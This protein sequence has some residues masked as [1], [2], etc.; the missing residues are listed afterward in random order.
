M[1]QRPMP[2]FRE[3][4]SFAA[5]WQQ[6]TQRLPPRQR[7]A[8]DAIIKH[9]A[10]QKQTAQ[11]MGISRE[12]ARQ[13]LDRSM[14]AIRLV[15]EQNPDSELAY[16][17]GA[18]TDIA[19]TAGLA[20][21][22]FHRMAPARR[23][24]I[25]ERIISAGALDATE[26]DMLTTACRLME[27]PPRQHLS[28]ELLEN[29][30]KQMLQQNPEG[31][32]PDDITRQH[33]H[34]KPIVASWPRLD[35]AQFVAMHLPARVTPQGLLCSLLPPDPVSIRQ[36]TAN[37]LF[38]ALQD[39]GECLAVP[40]ITSRAQ[41]IAQQQSSELRYADNICR[42]IMSKDPRFRWVGKSIYG[43]A[44]WDVGH[45]RPEAKAGRRIGVSDEIVFI[46]ENVSSMSFPDVMAHLER[47]FRLPEATI[48]AAITTSPQLTMH[49]GVVTR[50]DEAGTAQRTNSRHHYVLDGNTLKST[51]TLKGLSRRELAHMT[52]TNY[53]TIRRYENGAKIPRP[54]R[55]VDIARALEVPPE[56]LI[57]TT[58]DDAGHAILRHIANE[59]PT[60]NRK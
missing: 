34:L 23:R 50:N 6:A 53:N 24:N 4:S 30:A 11:Q 49:D 25:T 26:S 60:S 20:L 32:D 33:P 13:I 55:L 18:V 59:A 8:N 52:N 19:E 47:R 17:K 3:P 15:D 21:W 45:S 12:R 38:Q 9:G 31:L 5:E 56:D 44:Q 36:I 43:L 7:Q 29:A 46:L 2:I 16:T 57:L 10:T 40:D 14:R 41:E 22:A 37:L 1:I 42:D 35:I 48:R 51:R 39:T 27:T 58:V 28:L 54:R